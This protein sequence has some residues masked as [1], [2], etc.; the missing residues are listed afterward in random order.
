MALGPVVESRHVLYGIPLD[1][2]VGGGVL[3]AITGLMMLHRQ[4]KAEVGH[5]SAFSLISRALVPARFG[6]AFFA[7]TGAFSAMEDH[8]WVDRSFAKLGFVVSLASFALC[9]ALVATIHYLNAPAFLIPPRC[10][11]TNRQNRRN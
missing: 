11:T 5:E 7:L 9:R 4:W 6:F 10:R 1:F 2:I 8:G 3:M